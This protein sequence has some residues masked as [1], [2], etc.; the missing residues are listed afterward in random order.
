MRTYSSGMYSRLAFSVAVHVEPDILIIDEALSAEDARFKQK[1]A[2]KMKE[3]VAQARTMFLVSHAM[4]SEGPLLGRYLDAQGSIDDEGRPPIRLSPRTTS[5]SRSVRTPLLS[6]ISDPRARPPM[7]RVCSCSRS[8]P[9]MAM[10]AFC[11]RRQ[12]SVCPVVRFT[13]WAGRCLPASFRLAA[14]PAPEL[15]NRLRG[16]CADVTWLGQMASRTG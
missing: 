1:A 9:S 10:P 3:L 15:G 12:R 7:T 6:K 5:S 13:S 4:N 8:R 2:A 16:G 11:A 14:A